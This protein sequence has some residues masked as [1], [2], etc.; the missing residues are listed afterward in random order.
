MSFNICCDHLSIHFTRNLQYADLRV[1]SFYLQPSISISKSQ[2]L[3]S[4]GGVTVM[5]EPWNAPSDQSLISP[6]FSYS[7]I[8]WICVFEFMMSSIFSTPPCSQVKS[9]VFSILKRLSSSKAG[10][11]PST[12]IVFSECLPI[13]GSF[14]SRVNNQKENYTLTAIL[15]YTVDQACAILVYMPW[16]ALWFHNSG[17]QEQLVLSLSPHSH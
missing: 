1:F 4:F 17:W 14:K 7:Y 12:Y 11:K 5:T 8:F 15:G 2:L 9:H 10:I 6:Y 16:F 13:G 3:S